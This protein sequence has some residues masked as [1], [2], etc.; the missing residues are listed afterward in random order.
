MTGNG[1]VGIIQ[2]RQEEAVDFLVTGGKAVR[3]D[4][5]NKVAV[6]VAP[7]EA[8]NYGF[9][10]EDNDILSLFLENTTTARKYQ[11]VSITVDYV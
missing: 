7:A 6:T 11:I 1:A 2:D 8:P 5:K 9:F 3:S 4:V 10:L